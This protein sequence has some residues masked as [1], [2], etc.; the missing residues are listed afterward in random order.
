MG[1]MEQTLKFEIARLARK[2]VRAVCVPL[3]RDVR[4]LKRAVSALRKTAATLARLGAEYRAQRVTEQA[5]LEAPPEEVKAARLSAL[6]IKKLRKRLGI[7]QSELAALVGVSAGAV[8]FWEQGKARPQGRNRRALVALRQLGRREVARILASKA[9]EA[10]A[11]P[12][13]RKA[14]RRTRKAATAPKAR[15]RARKAAKK[16]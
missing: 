9:G 1:R 6:L 5:R 4:Q 8:G 7:T 12:K 2:Q 10:A 16:R 15:G 11:A 3:A 14:R 13:A